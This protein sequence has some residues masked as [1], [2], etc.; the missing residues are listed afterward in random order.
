MRVVGLAMVGLLAFAAPA[1]ADYSATLVGSTATFTSDNPPGGDGLMVR[2][3]ADGSFLQHNRV[4]AGDAGYFSNLDF[5]SGDGATETKLANTSVAIVNAT[6]GV[7]IDTFD[8]VSNAF[9]SGFIQAA[10]SFD[11]AG[12]SDT[13][14]VDSSDGDDQ[15]VLSAASIAGATGGPV[16]YSNQE[17]LRVIGNGGADS[18]RLNA[19][20]GIPTQV[21]AGAGN[22]TFIPAEG[23]ALT[24]GFEGNGGVDTLDYSGWTSPVTIGAATTATFTATLDGAQQSTPTGSAQTGTGQLQFTNLSAPTQPFSFSLNV[25]AFPQAT[26]PVTD[27]HIHG[28]APGV[29][30]GIIFPIGDASNYTNDGSG[31]LSIFRAGQTDP[32]ITEPALRAGNTYFNIHTQSF[33]GGEIRGQIVLDPATGYSQA[34]PGTGGVTG[35]E[36]FVGGAGADVIHGTPL[37]NVITGGGGADRL[38]GEDGG[39]TLNAG[40]GQTDTEINCGGGTGDVANRDLATID[41]DSI[42]ANCETVNTP[43]PPA[44]ET[45]P[46][47]TPPTETPPAETPPADDTPL[48]KT[49]VVTAI[50]PTA[51]GKK[52]I[53][54]DTSSTGMCPPGAT[55]ACTLNGS[56]SAKIPES[57]RGAK[58]KILGS[59]QSSLVPGQTSAR[60]SFTVSKKLSKAWRE[61]KKLKVTIS[62]QLAVP[63]GTAAAQSAT[64]K[65]KAPK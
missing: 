43:P 58:P 19:S 12:G 50:A 40:D 48:S 14:N 38:F 51:S 24:Q 54:I 56:A 52:K 39:D 21:F 36:N 37:A 60:I 7:G 34:A 25:G 9:G 41:P 1:G 65:I 29:D 31:N 17:S 32:D 5:V 64:Q 28:G 23:T 46:T 6:G 44:T 16:T 22:D 61:A 4:T 45:P 42:V 33:P 62:I 26:N 55:A 8:V 18:F 10:L 13:V 59:L 11:G 20:P 30:G 53:K 35:A 27:S 2:A 3:T 15:I 63:G 49:G 57:A 47:E